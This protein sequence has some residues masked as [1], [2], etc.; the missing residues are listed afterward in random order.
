MQ[1]D[2]GPTDPLWLLWARELQ[3]I[4]QTGLAFTRDPY[5]RE[6]Y[7]RLRGLTARIM[8]GH[9]QRDV[10]PIEAL[11]AGGTGYA[12]PKLD[13]RGAVFRDSRL[14]L[15]QETA[16]GDRWTLPG[17]WADVNES[18]SES[19]V[20]EVREESGFNVHV[21]KLAAVWDRARHPHV[22]PYAFDIW[23]LFFVCEITGGEARGGLETSAV[24]FFAE[25]ELP[26]DLSIS[27]VLLPQLQR[28][29][30]HMRRPELPTDF[31]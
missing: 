25:E 4:A 24:E 18:P 27:R 7:Q 9:T 29:F 13:V 20:K 10:Q 17:G 12:T 14:L 6:R 1:D 16:D 22:P 19:V 21:T 2:R 26:R 28:M 5:D 11:F 8:T 31:D 3:A 30:E 23:K 15:V